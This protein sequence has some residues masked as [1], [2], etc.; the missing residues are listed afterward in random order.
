VAAYRTVEGPQASRQP[1]AAAL[2]AGPFDALVFTSGSTI[3]GLL[4]LLTPQDRRIALRSIAWC[5]GPAT[6]TVAREHGF[7][8]VRAAATRSA[9]ALATEISAELA[10]PLLAEVTP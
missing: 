8:R 7:G 5:I 3:R 10:T 1:L 6:A 9:E 4:A 2:A